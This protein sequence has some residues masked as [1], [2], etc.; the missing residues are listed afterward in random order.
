MK[1]HSLLPCYFITFFNFFHECPPNF[2]RILAIF[3]IWTTFTVWAFSFLQGIATNLCL[4]SH[5]SYKLIKKTLPLFLCLLLYQLQYTSLSSYSFCRT[6]YLL[7]TVTK[8]VIQTVNGSKVFSHL[9]LSKCKADRS[10]LTAADKHSPLLQ[11][12]LSVG[13]KQFYFR[14]LDL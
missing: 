7:A 10:A 1:K 6:S 2:S 9:Q 5:M 8:I 11:F 3:F 13:L 14:S 12:W 4:P